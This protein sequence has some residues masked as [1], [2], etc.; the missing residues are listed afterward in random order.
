VA[1]KGD[2]QPEVLLTVDGAE[3]RQSY[4]HY[5]VCDNPEQFP[6]SISLDLGRGQLWQLRRAMAGD[7]ACRREVEHTFQGGVVL[8]GSD[9]DEARLRH[10]HYGDDRHD[11]TSHKAEEQSSHATSAS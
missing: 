1:H 10:S 11:E 8:R 6:I 2:N 9:I 5:A 7:R 3:G 4:G